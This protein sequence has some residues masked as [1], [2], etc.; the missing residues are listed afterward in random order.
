MGNKNP[1]RNMGKAFNILTPH[2]RA[3]MLLYIALYLQCYPRC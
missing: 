3:C 2:K 1:H